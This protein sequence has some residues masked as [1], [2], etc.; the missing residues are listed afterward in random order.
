MSYLLF[1]VII[2]RTLYQSK[3]LHKYHQQVAI[4]PD[5]L[6][7]WGLEEEGGGDLKETYI[8]LKNKSERIMQMQSLEIKD[9]DGNNYY[10]NVVNCSQ[11]SASDKQ[12][13]TKPTARQLDEKCK[14]SVGP[15]LVQLPLI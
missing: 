10:A 9:G 1:L 13:K 15:R 2:K 6:N 3:A 11:S 8:R 14:C 4:I 5:K 7:Y 12:N